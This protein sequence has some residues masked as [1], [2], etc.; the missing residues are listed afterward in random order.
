MSPFELSQRHPID[1]AQGLFLIMNTFAIVALSVVGTLTFL[2]L[3]ALAITVAYLLVQQ[4]KRNEARKR[5]TYFGLGSLVATYLGA[6]ASSIAVDRANS[7]GTD[8]YLDADVIAKNLTK[9]TEEILTSF[10]KDKENVKTP[11]DFDKKDQG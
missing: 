3:I 10:L 9:K 11:H 6:L 7:N 1:Y 5:A 4:V 2:T 8:V